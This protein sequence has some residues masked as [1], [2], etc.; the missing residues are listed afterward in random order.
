MANS[1]TGTGATWPNYSSRN[2]SG[3]GENSNVLGKDQFLKILITQLRNQDPAAPMQDREFIAQMAQ[4]TSLEQMM[5]MGNEIKMLRQSLGLASSVIGQQVTWM[6]YDEAGKPTGEQAGVVEA[7]IM[8]DGAQLA[9]VNGQ[10][11]NL[12]NITKIEAITA[13][14]SAI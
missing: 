8:R 6:T 3:N 11:V 10:E 1:V 2:T 12:E 5:N 7:I 13:E 14:N 4:F 9:K